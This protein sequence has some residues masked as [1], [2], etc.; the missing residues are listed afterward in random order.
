VFS[1]AH[2]CHIDE[3]GNIYV[4][5]WNRSGR[6]TNRPRPENSLS[7]DS[8][9]LCHTTRSVP[10]R[11]VNISILID[12]A[13][14]GRAEY[15]RRDILRIHVVISPLG[16]L[17]VVS[18]KRHRHIVFIKNRDSPLQLRHDGVVFMETHRARAAQVER[19]VANK[20]DIQIKMTE[21]K[22][23]PVAYQE[24]RLI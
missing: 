20:F 22:V 2:G 12:V 23:F 21:P 7:L 8:S 5:D 1:A 19:D 14:M 16:F 6:V 18:Q 11:D 9:Q 10:I 3:D 13:S 15:R 24:E 4:S 17:R